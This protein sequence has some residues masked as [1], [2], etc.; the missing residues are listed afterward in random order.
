MSLTGCAT[1]ATIGLHTS[2]SRAVHMAANAQAGVTDLLQGRSSTDRSPSSDTRNSSASGARKGPALFNSLFELPRV[3]F[4]ASLLGVSWSAL[5]SE[6]PKGDGH[7][8]MVLPGF[9]GG[10]ESTLLLRRFLTSL[11][12]QV[13]PWLQGRNL[14]RPELLEGAMRRFYRAYQAYETPISLVGQSLGGVFSREIARQFP[15]ATRCVITLGSP[16]AATE[17]GNTNPLVARLFEQMSGL[18]VEEMRERFGAMDPRAP[19]AVPASA[20]YSRQD[21]VVAWDT[22]IDRDSDITENIEVLGSHS[23]MAMAPDVL[24]VVADRLAQHPASWTK[25]DRHRGLRCL[26]YPKPATAT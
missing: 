19:L 17:H 16:F 13:L 20:V 1:L 14:G 9:M 25:F 22:C 10:D 8:V 15:D 4:E 11:G 7:P 2:D 5:R 26:F 23:G 21:G 12:Y 6:A 24:H 3:L 18:S